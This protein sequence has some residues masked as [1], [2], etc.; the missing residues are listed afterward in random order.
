MGLHLRTQQQRV[1]VSDGPGP[2]LVCG[3]SGPLGGKVVEALVHRGAVIRGLVRSPEG[4]ARALALGAHETALADLRDEPAVEH[5]L[6]G[7]AAAFFFC[8]KALPDEASLGRAFIA[9]AERAGVSRIVAISMLQAEAPIPNHRA[10]LAIEEALGRTRLEHTI[11]RSGMFMQMLP[12]PAQ[13]QERGWVG[14]PYPVDARISVVDQYE[15]AE[16]AAIALMEDHLANGTFEL[17]SQGMTSMAEIA[18]TLSDALGAPI[19]AR[20]V[21]LADWAAEMGKS[22]ASP[23]RRETYEAMFGHFPA[24]G[25]KGGNGFVLSKIIGRAP[26]SFAEYLARGGR[27][28]WSGSQATAGAGADV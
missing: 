5:A 7:C 22:F 25:F 10:S 2:F 24:Y 8:P 15:V 18:R 11:L 13:I 9:A 1:T 17:S 4:A 23:Y 14:R 12:S 16:V 26:S 3:S 20:Q 19:E 28:P 27:A 21:T 6:G